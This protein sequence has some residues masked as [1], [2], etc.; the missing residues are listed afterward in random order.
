MEEPVRITND[1]FEEKL[2]VL[3]DEV[4]EL[5]KSWEQRRLEADNQIIAL[6]AKLAAYQVALKDYWE[7]MDMPDKLKRI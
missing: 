2:K 6:D 3:I 1:E 5:R 7:R 4:L